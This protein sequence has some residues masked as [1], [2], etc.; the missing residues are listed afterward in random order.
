MLT[1]SAIQ[2]FFHADYS[3]TNQLLKQILEP[4][5]GECNL[6][7]DEITRSQTIKEKAKAAHIKTI[8]HVAT[9]W[10]EGLDIK[11]FDVTLD[12]NCHIHIARKNIQLLV[13]EYVEKFEGAFIVFHYENTANR[14]WRLSYLEKRQNTAASTNAKR[15]TYLC[16]KDYPC[17]T[18]AERFYA[19]QSQDLNAI[20][21]EKA[22]SVEALSDEFFTEYTAQYNNICNYIYDNRED[23]T[24]F[25]EE[26][27]DCEDKFIRDY[28]KKMMGRITFLHFL[29][30]KGWMG[31]PLKSEWGQGD[32]NFMRHLFEYATPE[33]QENFLDEILE[34]LFFDCLN[35]PR[36]NDEFD[37]HI[38]KIGKV[39]IP[40]LNGGLFEKD[41]IDKPQSTLPSQ[42][43][44]DLLDFY[45]RF[46][47]TIDENDPLDA[48]VG[49]DPEMLGK[50]FENLLE[51]NKD[52][53]AFYTPK[54]IV[55]YMCKESLIAYLITEAHQA[56]EVN[57]Q[58]QENFEAAI[59]ALVEDPEMT[60]SRI[61]RYDEK[62]LEVLSKALMEVKICDPA[63]GSGAFPMGLLNLLFKCRN[64][65]N[66]ALG[67]SVPPAELKKDIIR[68]NIYGV[69]IEKGAIDI[70]RLRFWLSIVVDLEEPEALPNFDYKFMQ[71]NSLLE[72]FAGVDLSD[73]FATKATEGKGSGVQLISFDEVTTSQSILQERLRHYFGMH[74]GED[75][76]LLREK[77]NQAVADLISAK[78]NEAPELVS[79]LL[80][81]D[82]SA[83]DQFFL[84]H[85]WFAEVFNRPSKQGFD[86]VI[87][88]PPYGAKLSA[89]DKI[90]CK[91]IYSTAKTISG[92]QKGSLDTFSLFIELGFRLLRKNGAFGMII[93]LS[94][95][96]SDSMSGVHR[97]LL[98]NC[99]E[100]HVSSYAV[101]PEPVFKNAVVNTSILSF[102]KTETQCE[103]LMSTRLNRKKGADFNL[104]KLVDN[105]EFVNVNDLL[106]YGRIP[107]ISTPI[108]QDILRKVRLGRTISSYK[109]NHGKPIY[110]RFAGGRYFKVITNYTTN[111]SAERRLEL[112][113]RYADV[114]GCILSS[115]L[116]FWFYQIYSDNLNWK[117][118][119]IE[120]FTIPNIDEQ[121]CAKLV[122]LYNKYLVD[123]EA[124]ANIRTSSGDSTYNVSEFK[125]YKIVRSKSIID[126]IDDTIG[127]LYGLTKEEIEFIK[128]YEI[129]FRMAGE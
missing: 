113:E 58:R 126:E 34:P 110:Y 42:L 31:V 85:T 51:D 66:N 44:K 124:N 24:R 82:V 80:D 122:Q 29:Q 99:K 65:V 9:F 55:N 103:R 8:K 72:Q 97:L 45:A 15:Y 83:N 98:S 35:S 112:D 30:K 27:A 76:H 50:I 14:S 10:A 68:N 48:E 61:K 5:F 77:V 95:T 47:F 26:F 20:N 121:T 102:V 91:R 107:K 41:D 40:Y 21:L 54:E 37:T 105:L 57:K 71:G 62:Q 28:V 36:N 84:W 67:Q 53:G 59:R 18:I 109:T 43:F 25:G 70:A 23:A 16:G 32:V 60:V 33:Q 117:A 119:E 127:V 87:G 128:D 7:Y 38:T 39:R 73:M 92:V 4:I 111:S 115:N 96:S 116:S 79:Q 49:V 129:E 101:R 1:Q 94:F 114:I 13:R 63:I 74:T 56:S 64:A 120:N 52:K 17:R 93:P 19:L 11:V 6:G 46:N 12:D 118:N 22:F 125:E 88:N 78:V 100:I 3:G 69:D 104:Q 108:E 81:L 89:E 90:V 75:K 106:M 86:I 2:S 123:I